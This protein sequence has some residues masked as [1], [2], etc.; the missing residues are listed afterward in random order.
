MCIF[1]YF[2]FV[3]SENQHQV[4]TN[5]TGRDGTSVS[6]CLLFAP[7]KYFK[8]KATKI[9]LIRTLSSSF[10]IHSNNNLA[11]ELNDD[12][13]TSQ[14]Q[15]Q[16]Q[17]SSATESL[18]VPT[19]ETS[20]P[21][22]YVLCIPVSSELESEWRGFTHT[23]PENKNLT[24][25]LP[26][27][28]TWKTTTIFLLTQQTNN[29]ENFQESF[30]DCLSKINVQQSD[31]YNFDNRTG[32]LLQR[33]SCF[34]KIDN[35]MRNLAHSMLNL[36]TCIANNVETFEKLVE[37]HNTRDYV[38]SKP[39]LTLYVYIHNFSIIQLIKF[40]LNKVH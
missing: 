20:P 31:L 29:L 39:H 24:S 25:I 35:A 5:Q 17:S 4:G 1:I 37:E 3:A 6:K 11:T 15:Q 38:V 10:R 33:R 27:H 19:N 22:V 21:L 26:L 13:S 14:Q 2:S 12:L 40:D 23:I 34:E 9:Q 18:S 8:D 16:L 7:G 30:K 36:S 32:Q 28:T